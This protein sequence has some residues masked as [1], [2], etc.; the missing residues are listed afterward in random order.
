VSVVLCPPAIAEGADMNLMTRLQVQ[1]ER[2]EFWPRNAQL[3]YRVDDDF[4]A[5][6]DALVWETEQ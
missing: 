3:G 6:L 4:L 1:R 2:R 5:E